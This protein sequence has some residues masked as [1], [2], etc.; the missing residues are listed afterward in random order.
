MLH[1]YRIL[2]SVKVNG[3]ICIK[4]EFL[5]SQNFHYSN[6]NAGAMT[7]LISFE[8]FVHSLCSFH[9]DGPLP[10]VA[11]TTNPNDQF[12]LNPFEFLLF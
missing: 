2:F 11:T 4:G 3:L 7:L 1:K 12:K 5:H 9:S 10:D 6:F 8:H